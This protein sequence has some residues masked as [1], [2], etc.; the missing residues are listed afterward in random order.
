MSMIHLLI[1]AVH[2]LVTIAKIMRPGGV[3]AE[4]LLLKYQLVIS[5]RARRAT[6]LCLIRTTWDYLP[7]FQISAARFQSIPVP[8][9]ISTRVRKAGDFCGPAVPSRYG[10]DSLRPYFD[11]RLPFSQP[12]LAGI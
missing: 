10:V 7:S 11:L 2:L 1:L 3:L 9:Q 5:S 4:S 12:R 8:A 6:I